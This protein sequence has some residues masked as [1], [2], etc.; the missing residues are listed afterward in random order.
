MGFD[1]V[2]LE[3]WE[4][5]RGWQLEK[6]TVEMVEPRYNADGVATEIEALAS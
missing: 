1:D 2:H 4:F 5:G 6:L 3:P